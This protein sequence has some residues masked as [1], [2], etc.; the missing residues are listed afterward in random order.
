MDPL[1]KV[2]SIYW[3]QYILYMYWAQNLAQA[4]W[5]SGFQFAEQVYIVDVENIT[6]KGN[7]W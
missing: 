7:Y 2:S 5:T 1:Y 4:S 6:T 3:A